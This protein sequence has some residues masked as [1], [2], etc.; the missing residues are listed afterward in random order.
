ME[1]DQLREERGHTEEYL[2][3]AVKLH[4]GTD[5]VLHL[6]S[7]NLRLAVTLHVVMFIVF[8]ETR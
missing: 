3:A 1:V 8:V 7:M 2:R 4:T 5:Q 6:F